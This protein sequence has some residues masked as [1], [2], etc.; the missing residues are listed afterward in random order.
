MESIAIDGPKVAT[1]C[2]TLAVACSIRCVW[3]NSVSPER[4]YKDVNGQATAASEAKAATINAIISG[5]LICGPSIGLSTAI[6]SSKF[7]A[8]IAPLQWDILL[9]TGP[10]IWALLTLQSFVVWQESVVER[11][12]CLSHNASISSMALLGFICLLSLPRHPVV[13]CGKTPVTNESGVSIIDWI[14]FSWGLH[15]DCSTL[16]AA[17]KLEDVPRIPYRQTASATRKQYDSRL[18]VHRLLNRL[19]TSPAVDSWTWTWVA[20]LMLSLISVSVCDKW[21]SWIGEA[22]IQLPM[23]GLLQSLA[24]EKSMRLRSGGGGTPTTE[25]KKASLP[26]AVDVIMS[27]SNVIAQAFINAHSLPIAALKVC[28][29]SFYLSHLMGFTNVAIGGTLPVLAIVLSRRLSKNLRVAQSEHLNAQERTSSLVSEALHGLRQIRLSSMESLWQ[30]RIFGARNKNLA[31][32]WTVSICQELINL[33]ASLGPVL[34]ASIT[35]SMY[36]LRTGHF[37]SSTVFTAINLFGNL[38]AVIKQ[39]PNRFASLHRTRL[40]Y[41]KVRKY[42][43]QAEQTPQSALADTILLRNAN[44]AWAEGEGQVIL[45]NVNLEFPQDGLSLITGQVGSGKSLL[46]STILDEAIVQFGTLGKPA[47]SI[48]AGALAETNTVAGSVAFVSQPPWI[49]DCTVKD[50]I[51]FGHDFDEYR[52]HQVL[53]ACALTHD[54]AALKSGDLTMAGTGGSALSGGQK[55]RVALARAL[56]SPAEFI[57][58]EDILAAVDAPIARQICE[59][60]L[61]GDLLQGRTMILATH[62]PEYCSKLASCVVSLRDGSATATY[63]PRATEKSKSSVAHEM[64]ESKPMVE[65]AGSSA[66]S[67]AAHPP[68]MTHQ[69]APQVSPQ[70]YWATLRAYAFKSGSMRGYLFAVPVVLCYRLIATSNSWWLAKWTSKENSVAPQSSTTYDVGIYLL[71][72]VG[73]SIFLS[74]QTLLF[75]RMGHNSSRKLFESLMRRVLKARLSWIDSTPPGQ[76]A[77]TLGSDMYAIDHRMA[78]QIIHIISSVMNILFICASSISTS[79]Y[80]VFMSTMMLGCYILVSKTSLELS[81]KLRPV[82]NSCLFPVSN[83]VSSAQAGLTTIRAFGKVGHYVETM[84]AHIDRSNSTFTHMIIGHRWLG[85]RLGVISSIFTAAVTA[86]TIL[87]HGTASSTGL[88][89]TLALQLRQSL[90]TTIG[91]INVTRTGLNAIDRVLALASIPS[92]EEEEQEKPISPPVEWPANGAVE[93][94]S[95]GVRYAKDLPWA[96]NNISFSITQGRRLGIV[97][98]TGAGKSS[99]INALLRF[100]DATEGQILI[101]GQDIS[102]IPR[103]YVRDAVTV[104]PQDAFLFS[105][106]LRSNVDLHGKHSDERII[107]VLRCVGFDLIDTESNMISENLDKEILSG[108]SNISHGQRQLVCLARVI[109]EDRCRIMILDEATSG[110]DHDTEKIIQRALRE[111]FRDVTIL[112]VAHKLLTVA[113]FDTVLVLS[114]GK[115]AES[116][117]PQELLE[118]KGMFWNMVEQ[119]EDAQSVMQLIRRGKGTQGE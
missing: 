20:L 80:T 115:V 99:L 94:Q 72:S 92:E 86:V 22:R 49:E 84:Q 71:L 23:L 45:E 16:P 25:K 112:V 27:H 97:G 11:R 62:R 37:S 108:G 54:L 42:L 52:Y 114:Q 107:A 29:Y 51:L 44:L 15:R 18:V 74:F 117:T 118:S 100:V 63:T 76:V 32:A 77:Q 57:I 17:L 53:H 13:F 36:A 58:S 96:L 65:D 14:F 95:L 85:I 8:D 79:P 106:T 39:L 75:T 82:T 113:D 33:V 35:I 41:S 5:T 59:K 110:I 28:L 3:P 66:L 103:K 9:W 116:G 6:L 7:P 34:F 78:P 109:L 21:S 10:V 73:S 56:Y 48:D 64:N 89:I 43:Q 55:W 19:E 93:T 104:I 2:L 47:K 24:F 98:R 87:N 68:T 70:D 88:A 111:N 4:P 38:H 30:A 105:G 90:N 60:V 91:H 50:N 46:L 102:Q 31:L 67:K 40:S 81:Q 101:G 26:S 119:S 12:Y 61:G 1:F 69:P 83:H